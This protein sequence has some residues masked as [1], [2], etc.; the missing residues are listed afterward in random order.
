MI[1]VGKVYMNIEFQENDGISLLPSNEGWDKT[2]DARKEYV[3]FI[4]MQ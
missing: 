4:W 3:S 1:D 2:V